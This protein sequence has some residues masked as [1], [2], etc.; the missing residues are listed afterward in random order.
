[1]K[2]ANALSFCAAFA[3]TACAI[4]VAGSPAF[5][6]SAPIVVTAQPEMTSRHIGYA[7]LNLAS[8]TGERIL[9]RRVNYAIGD[10][11]VEVTG[12]YSGSST[13]DFANVTC[14]RS[15]WQQARPQMERA[16]QRAREIALT[17]K[18]SIAAAALTISIP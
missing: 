17:G 2:Y 7:D 5:G 12:G 11:C 10:L 1:M 8:A 4:F 15:A 18:S 3:I 14:S 9:N 16:V 6:K 13:L